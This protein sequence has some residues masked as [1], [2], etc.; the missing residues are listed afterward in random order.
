MFNVDILV[1]ISG[2]R[3][4][5]GELAGESV[6]I[7]GGGLGM[8]GGA[9]VAETSPS[10]RSRKGFLL[11]FGEENGFERPIVANF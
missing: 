10:I 1:L 11:L 7:G 5:S 4:A 8:A 2:S 3:D 9:G 6:D